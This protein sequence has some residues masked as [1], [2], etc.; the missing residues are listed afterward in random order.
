M[1]R[2][3]SVCQPRWIFAVFKCHFTRTLPWNIE[4]VIHLLKDSVWSLE[5]TGY[6]HLYRR[7]RASLVW[8]LLAGECQSLQH[9]GGLQMFSEAI[10]ET[11]I[12]SL[13]ANPS[14]NKELLV[15]TDRL[16]P[17]L[18]M[19]AVLPHFPDSCA[20]ISLYVTT[21]NC[22]SW[23]AYLCHHSTYMREN[24]RGGVQTF[25]CVQQNI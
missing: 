20:L 19:P 17:R 6:R 15:I 10:S 23:V 22:V 11:E 3:D 18:G 7:E 9:F 4:V 24:E 21:W 16:R 12:T 13:L 25:T 2:V 1:Q 8:T 14:T 5:V